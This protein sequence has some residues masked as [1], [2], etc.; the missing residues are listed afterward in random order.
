MPQSSSLT[1]TMVALA[2]PAAAA[3]ILTALRP[4]LRP[5]VR[6]SRRL[7]LVVGLTI[8]AQV[9]HFVE[10][11]RTEL[12]VAFPTTFGFPAAQLSVFVWANTTA[13]V[14]WAAALIAVRQGIVL[15]LL[16]LWFLG[17]CALLNLVL[18]PYLALTT[19]GYYPGVVTAPLVGVLGIMTIREL[20]RVTANDRENPGVTDH[21]ASVARSR[22]PDNDRSSR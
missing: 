12:Y 4:R 3:V 11:L 13:L 14:V 19:G 16:P 17:F 1:P 20:A 8:A 2:A 9:L 6:G 7:L 22:L 10:E 15:A 21:R 18:H 5:D